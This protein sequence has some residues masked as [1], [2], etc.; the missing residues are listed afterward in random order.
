MEA[1]EVINVSFDDIE[2]MEAINLGE[3]TKYIRADIAEQR[4]K[5]LNKENYSYH[6]QNDKLKQKPKDQI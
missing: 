3:G 2:R 1:P 6:D 5:E 4:E